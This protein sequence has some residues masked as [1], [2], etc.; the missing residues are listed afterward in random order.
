MLMISLR[1]F[2]AVA[3]DND[4]VGSEGFGGGDWGARDVF[5]ENDGV[6]LGQGGGGE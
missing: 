3:G 5:E 2:F 6:W 4:G 1:P